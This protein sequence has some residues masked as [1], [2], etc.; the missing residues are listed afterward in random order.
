MR[1]P[2]V[3]KVVVSVL[4]LLAG[5]AAI[6]LYLEHPGIVYETSPEGVTYH[7]IVLLTGL[8]VIVLGYYGGKI[9]WHEPQESETL[10]HAAQT[11]SPPAASRPQEA[12]AALKTLAAAGRYEV[13]FSVTADD[14]AAVL[15]AHADT[16]EQKGASRS[17]SVLIGGAAGLG[18]DT[19]EKLLSEAFMKSGFFVY[20][21]KEFMSRVRGGSNTTLI[22]I[23]DAPLEAPCWEVDLYIA[24]DAL[25]LE[26]AKPRMTEKTV[27][28]ADESFSDAAAEAVAVPL[29]QKAKEL[30]DVRYGNTYAAGLVYGLFGLE[31]A[32]LL[33]SVAERFGEDE[34]NEKAAV[35]GVE[36]GRGLEHPP[37]PPL[38]EAAHE[39]VKALHLMDGTTASGF[40]FLSGGCNFVG[41][42]PLSPSTGVLTFMA[43]MSKHFD[44]AVEQS[45][46][47][48]ASI[49][50]VMGASY[51][52]ARAMTTTSGGGFAL[53][54]EGIS[55]AGITETPVVV[56]LAQRPGPATGMPTRSEQG[57]LNLAMHSGHGPFPRI[58]WRRVR[59]MSAS[60]WATSPSNWRTAG[61][62]PSSF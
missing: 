56:Y 58:V 38:P 33:E 51:A 4:M 47:E 17:V 39:Q 35:A 3:V 26:H 2:F 12:E 28:L 46:D 19:L 37:L 40:G 25:A 61:S 27:I 48:I 11:E 41:A 22:R 43:S 10:K 8:G 54:G 15:P 45:E 36:A 49:H 30:G 57:D 18:I 23:A 44:I 53:M 6:A 24:L 52:G 50:L 59:W 34:G 5:I 62:S 42:Y 13:P 14:P 32:A 29:Q 55:L 9:T 16:G 1:S 7:A 21:S 20:S 60:I 31:S